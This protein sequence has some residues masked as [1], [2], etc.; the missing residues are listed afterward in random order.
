MLA[1]RAFRFGAE[2]QREAVVVVT[3][4]RVG[5]VGPHHGA[6]VPGAA[7][8][9]GID[10]ERHLV[11]AETQLRRDDREQLPGEELVRDGLLGARAVR[12]DLP[13]R[14]GG[15]RVERPSEKVCG[16]GQFRKQQVY[17]R[18]AGQLTDQVVVGGAEAGT[19]MPAVA[20]ARVEHSDRPAV[21]LRGQGGGVPQSLQRDGHRDRPDARLERTPPRDPGADRVLVQPG[22]EV[23]ER[24]V[25]VSRLAGEQPGLCQHGQVLQA[26]EFPDP[27]RVAACHPL[28]DPAG[29]YCGPVVVGDR[30]VVPVD[31]SDVHAGV[32]EVGA[33]TGQDPVGLGDQPADRGRVFPGHLAGAVRIEQQR[34]GTGLAEPLQQCIPIGCRDVEHLRVGLLAQSLVPHQ[35]VGQRHSPP[36]HLARRH[37]RHA[38]GEPGQSRRFRAV[39]VVPTLCG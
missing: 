10:P 28:V 15:Q 32:A 21:P 22:V 14:F 33:V 2:P 37:R 39:P 11:A 24:S 18:Q 35:C 26:V 6:Q 4:A 1:H 17:R 29:R 23:V 34:P 8:Q 31:G 12:Q 9:R 30:V 3:V 16:A 13:V 36:E 25:G 7:I 38:T 19:G 27:L 5:V 20:G